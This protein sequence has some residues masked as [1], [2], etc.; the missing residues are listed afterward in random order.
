MLDQNLNPVPT[1][2]LGEIFIGGCGVARGYLGRPEL[3]AELFLPNGHGVTPG[4]RMYR[5]GDLGRWRADHQLEVIGRVDHQVKIRGF[6]VEPAEIESALVSHPDIAEAVV[7]A[8]EFGPGNRQ[9]VAYYTARRGR[10][11]R[12]C[13]PIFPPACPASWF[14]AVFIALDHAAADAGRESRP[15]GPAASRG[16]GRREHRRGPTRR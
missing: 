10:P 12:A 16:R 8:H 7:I 6:R 1:G 2:E 4:S 5:T 3:T 9:L 11:T 14:P 13:G 15:A